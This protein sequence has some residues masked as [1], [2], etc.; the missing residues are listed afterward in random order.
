[1][2]VPQWTVPQW[3]QLK[4]APRIAHLSNVEILRSSGGYRQREEDS[5]LGKE[6]SMRG[7]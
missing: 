7:K 5:K 2:Q 6:W 4:L 3:T 1:M